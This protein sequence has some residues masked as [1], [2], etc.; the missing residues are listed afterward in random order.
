MEILLITISLVIFFLICL[1]RLDL[2]LTVLAMLLPAYVVRFKVGFLPLTFLEGA[3]LVIF[4][5][6][7]IRNIHQRSLISNIQSLTSK[8]K[9]SKF[10]IPIL[11][12]FLA[13]LISV[14]VSPN[15]KSALGIWKAYFAE[16][17]LLFLI[18]VSTIKTKRQLRLIL[19]GLGISALWVS[20]IAIY[21]KFTGWA[22]PD[23]LWKAEETRRVTSIYG[24]P[25][26]LGL[27]LGPIIILHLGMLVSNFKTRLSIIIYQLSVIIVS[28]LAVIF[29]VS[30][31]AWVGIIA[32][33]LFL[34]LISR[35]KKIVLIGF[36]ILVILI[37]SIPLFRNYVLPQIT[38]K[39]SSGDV[40]LALW[41]GTLR[42]LKAHPIF[43]AG[44]AGFQTKYAQYKL[45][46]HVE[47][48]VY[49]HNI[50]FNFWTETGLLGLIVFIWLMVRFFKTGFAS[51][52]SKSMNKEYKVLS[53][54]LMA[55][56]ICLLIHGLVDVPYFK[57]DLSA[58]FWILL[59]LLIIPNLKNQKSF[60]L[61]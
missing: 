34:G 43:G 47:L 61:R 1:F 29:A 44:L 39:T 28:S 13:A 31:G 6:W 5:V 18:F 59:G 54:S 15:L 53:V 33:L 7:L 11:L 60:C 14:F 23:P 56:M 21:Q 9:E 40:R 2:G 37:F 48:L 45:A 20:L 52:K 10:F 16:P 51:L 30:Q 41:Q 57:N 8:L 58:L 50:I 12:F 25:N 3:I 4:L 49:P 32:G 35:H 55:A 26:A 38:F 22:I 19:Y 36:A 17:I 27:Y 24:Y 46:R 42:L